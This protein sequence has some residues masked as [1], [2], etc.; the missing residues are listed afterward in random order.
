MN[1]QIFKKVLR[2][3]VIIQPS[4]LGHTINAETKISAIGLNATDRLHL[5]D[6][7]NQHYGIAIS[8]DDAKAWQ[9]VADIVEM[10]ERKTR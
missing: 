2:I 5:R 4:V 9:T 10:V 1:T 8:A 6:R 3:M 7:L